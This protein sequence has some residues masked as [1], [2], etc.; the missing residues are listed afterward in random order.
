VFCSR[1]AGDSRSGFGDGSDVRCGFW[2]SAAS[3]A[4]ADEGGVMSFM[5]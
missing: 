4:L 1:A 3:S 5:S 2:A